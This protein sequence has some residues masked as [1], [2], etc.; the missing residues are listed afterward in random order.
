MVGPCSVVKF[1]CGFF[2][3]A[4]LVAV[5]DALLSVFT[6]QGTY[7]PLTQDQIHHQDINAT[8]PVMCASQ[9]SLYLCALSV[10]ICNN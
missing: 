8:F 2:H 3:R 9:T 5:N 7:S 4:R 10:F 1:F 6:E